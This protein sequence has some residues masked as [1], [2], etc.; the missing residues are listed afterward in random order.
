MCSASDLVDLG[1]V[2][3]AAA[4]ATGM[5]GATDDLGGCLRG[6]RAYGVAPGRWRGMRLRRHC[7]LAESRSILLP[8]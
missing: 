5:T 4:T 8:T 3:R 7:R 6:W 2:V 1:A